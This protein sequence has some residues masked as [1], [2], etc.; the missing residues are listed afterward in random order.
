MTHI[1]RRAVDPGRALAQWERYVETLAR[2]RWEVLEVEGADESPDSVFVEDTLVIFEDLAVVA[3]PGAQ[4]RRVEL[5]AAERSVAGLGCR[6]ARI[7]PPGTLDGGDVLRAG[8]VVYVGTGGRTN[9]EGAEQ[10]RRLLGPFG[11][12][13]VTVPIAGILHLKSALGALPDGSLVGFSPLLGAPDL[14][15]GLLAVPEPSGAQVL[16]LG[17]RALLLAND[18]P[19]SARLYAELGF[20]P[21]A[22]DISEF[23]KLEGAVTCLS[24]LLGS[25][26]LAQPL[27]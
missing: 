14:L 9:D 27:T 20:E 25:G 22:V 23:Q 19:R 8:T 7:E 1:P 3:R 10:L 21:V 13:V 15:P 12:R 6:V 2:Y 18:C 4:S 24:V 16:A 11:A 5:G 17:E 26:L